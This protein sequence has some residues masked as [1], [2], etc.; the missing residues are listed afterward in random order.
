MFPKADFLA[1]NGGDK[2]V[3]HEDILAACIEDPSATN[4]QGD[5]ILTGM[6][7]LKWKSFGAA[8]VALVLTIL[9][10]QKLGQAQ[11]MTYLT[12]QPVVPLYLGYMELPDG[13][14]DMHFGYLNKNWQEE[15]DVPLGPENSITPTALSPDGGQPTHFLPRVNRWQFTVR[16]PADFGS[17]EVVWTLTSHG[18]TNRA[19]GILKP[20]YILDDYVIQ[21]DFGSDSTHGRK[22]PLLKVDGSKERSVKVG[23]SLELVAVA[24]DPNPPPKPRAGRGAGQQRPAPPDEVSLGELSGAVGGDTIRTTPAGLRLAWYQYRGPG[25]VKFT[26]AQFKVW[27]DQRGGSPW[28]PGWRPPPVPPNNQWVIQATFPQPGTYVL[29]CLAHNGSRFVIE[30][31]TVNVSQ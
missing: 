16:V 3:S 27:E 19:Y 17:K 23:Q 22:D 1:A 4:Y 24:T 13:S 14:Y 11:E 20:G 10:F 6:L 31:I 8:L 18:Q 15:V 25:V 21:H 29:R 30:K 12:G 2:Q 5:T 26:P 9:V 7:S 28:S